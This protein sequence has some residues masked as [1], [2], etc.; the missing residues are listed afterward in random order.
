LFNRALS[1]MPRKVNIL[2]FR[3][4]QHVSHQRGLPSG[5]VARCV[6]WNSGSRAHALADASGIIH[7][8]RLGGEVGRR[9]S[10]SYLTTLS[11]MIHLRLSGEVGRAARLSR[12]T[13]ASDGDSRGRTRRA[14]ILPLPRV[15]AVVGESW[16]N[17]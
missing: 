8:V 14:L 9:T 4:I 1:S 7:H 2:G 3:K 11:G 15:P 6:Q 13:G 5:Y 16:A 17:P 12:Q 10:W